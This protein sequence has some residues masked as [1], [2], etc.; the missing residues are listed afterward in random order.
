MANIKFG[1]VVMKFT[2]YFT[3]ASHTMCKRDIYPIPEEMEGAKRIDV[4]DVA[5][6]ECFGGFGV[7]LTG[8]SCYCLSRMKKEE[9]TELLRSIFTTE[10]LGLSVARLTIGSSDYS[11]RLYSYDDVAGDTSLEHFSLALDEEYVIPMIK[12]IIEICPELYIF[13]S[14]WSPPGW[15]KTGGGMCGGYM[16]EEY[17]ECYADYIIKYLSEYERHGI[18]VRALTPQNEPENSQFGRMPACIWHPDTEVRFVKILKEKL[19]ALGMNTKVWMLDHA[20]NDWRRAKWQLDT[21]PE[22]SEIADGVAFHYYGGNP[23]DTSP[24]REAY[25]QLEYHFTEAGPRLNDNYAT[26]RCKWISVISRTLACGFSTFTGWNLMLDETGGPNIGPFMCGGLVTRSSISGE[27]SYSGQYKAFSHISRAIK[28]G[29][30]VYPVFIH[31]N[32]SGLAAYPKHRESVV[33]I[34]AKNT[35]GSFA[36]VLSNHHT[37]KRQLQFC[38]EGERYYIEMLPDSICSITD[39]T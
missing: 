7:A 36:L 33:G 6:V 3:D 14:P 17:I 31:E 2:Q 10:G 25:P 5:S 18:V 11:A 21:Y 1:R 22:L 15:M 16:R 27:L 9:R 8:A 32:T 29:A 23:E 34:A 28:R 35:D 13:A 30:A 38:Y 4:S 20:F 39:F 12:E 26:D 37:E 24:L 19:N